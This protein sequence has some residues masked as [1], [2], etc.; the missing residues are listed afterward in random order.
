MV[1]VMIDINSF[2]EYSKYLSVVLK[3]YIILV[4]IIGIFGGYKILTNYIPPTIIHKNIPP[5]LEF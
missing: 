4:L 1:I 3:V 5:E 2:R